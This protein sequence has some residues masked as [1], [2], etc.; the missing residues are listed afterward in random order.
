MN[1]TGYAQYQNE[2]Y[3]R[4]V[5]GEKPSLPIPIEALESLARETL[6]CEAYDYIAGGAGSE[7]TMR[8]NRE[9]FDHWR[10]VPRML[11]DVSTRDLSVELF[12]T[13]I[14][15]PVLFAPIGVQTLA[16]P[17]GEVATA[18][19][20][21]SLEL[22]FVYSTAATKT[23]EEVARANGDRPRWYQLYWPRDRDVT[24]NFLKRTEAAGYG[25][26]VVTLD[27]RL[28]AWRERDLGHAYLPMFKGNEGTGI[29]FSDPV[30]LSRLSKPPE[31]D[32]VAAIKAWTECFS[33]LSHNWDDL[34]FLREATSLP[35]V[36]KGI[37]HPDDAA[38]AVQLGI[39]GLIVSNHG[40]RQVDGGMAALDALPAVVSAVNGKVPVLFD[41]GIRRGSDIFKALALGA[42]AVLVGRPYMWGLAAGGDEG[43]AEVMN[44][45]L[46]DFDLTMA[47]SGFTRIAELTPS[48]LQR[49]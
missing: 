40:G 42:K 8:F 1:R 48:V 36:L 30:F 47:M 21:R 19:A 9:A 31:E 34:A 26:V 16:H 18:R 7:S 13:T 11:R 45:L 20:A 24:Q 4:G 14:P 32:P 12:G 6:P 33:D 29:Y 44:R 15:A 5:R 22:P 3:F 41:S 39:D 28:L 25:V 43:V 35:I 23:P 17:E 49:H 27:T 2:I 38:R 46:A 10:I 37:M